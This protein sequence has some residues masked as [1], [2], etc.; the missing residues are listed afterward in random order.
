MERFPDAP[1]SPRQEAR[2]RRA[3]DPVTRAVSIVRELLLWCA[4]P[5]T[6]ASAPGAPSSSVVP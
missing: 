3:A 5:G 1:R 2:L 4:L 6:S